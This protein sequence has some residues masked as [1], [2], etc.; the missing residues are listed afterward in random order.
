MRRR[1]ITL[2]DGSAV[3]LRRPAERDLRAL[4]SVF[5]QAVREGVYF[6][7]DRYR[8]DRREEHAWLHDRAGGRGLVVAAFT[9][10]GRCVGFVA[11]ERGRRTKNRHTAYLDPLVVARD[12]RGRGLG[13]ALMEE[14]IAWARHA[15]VEKL[16]LGVF[17]SNRPALS[18]YRT[19][20]FV[21]DGA[22]RRQFKIRRH[23]VDGLHMA[24]FLK[25]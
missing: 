15:R 7:N 16:W 25:R 13:R 4:G 18:L 5:G 20:G 3:V 6:G 11:V 23:Y 2:E 10:R 24:L 21:A 22:Q 1:T 9:A 12:H 8:F 14:A 17:G 19:L